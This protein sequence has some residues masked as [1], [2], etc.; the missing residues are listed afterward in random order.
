MGGRCAM[1]DGRR[2]ALPFTLGATGLCQSGRRCRAVDDGLFVP[3]HPP[4]K[5]CERERVNPSPSQHS[6][7]PEQEGVSCLWLSLGADVYGG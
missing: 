6:P 2:R 4:V 7:L 3:T 5:V 1:G